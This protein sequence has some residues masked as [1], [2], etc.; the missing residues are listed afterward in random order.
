[1]DILIINVPSVSLVYP[2]AAPSL[3]KGVCEQAGF[4]ASVADFNL[5]LFDALGGTTQT[6]VSNY[7]TVRSSIGNE[8]Q[9]IINDWYDSCVNQILEIN[10]KFL[11]ISVF[12]FECQRA[13]EELAQRL[14]GLYT[15]KIII[16][17]AGLSTNGIASEKNDFGTRLVEEKLVDFFIRGEGEHALVEILRKNSSTVSGLNNDDYV[18]ITNLDDIAFPNYD[19]VIDLPYRYTSNVEKQLP[20]TSSRGCVRSCTFCDIHAFWKKYTFRSGANVAEEMIHQYNKYGV[21]NFFFTDSLINGSIKSF[22]ELYKTLNQYYADNNLGDKFFTWGGQYIVRTPTQLNADDFAGAAR[23]GMN[24][25]AMGIESLSENVRDHMKKGFSNADLD[26]T[27]EQIRLNGMNCY[28]LIIIGYPTETV[29][30]FQETLES[31]TKYQGYAID[32]TIFGVNLGGTLSID[33][34]TPL[35]LNSVD[36]GLDFTSDSG[37]GTLFGLDW[38]DQQNKDLTLLERCRRR[39]STQELLMNLGYT[40]WNGDHQ[41][42]RLMRSYDRITRN[43]YHS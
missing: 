2:A 36:L 3:L 37:A 26:F 24:G 21:T 17:G 42:T 41:L 14:K 30:D 9:K 10:P 1:M 15:G 5:Q 11:G 39:V 8:D 12:T 27:L 18:Q 7:F 28:F 19:D 35:H 16:G 13:T 4:T 29:E 32:G 43:S 33:E 20:I 23:S 22:R 25:L 31:F 40:V 34:G 38:V 6:S